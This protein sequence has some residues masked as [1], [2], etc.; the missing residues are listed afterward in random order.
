LKEDYEAIENYKIT[1]NIEEN[2]PFAAGML[3]S[4]KMRICDWSDYQKNIANLKNKIESHHKVSQPMPILGLIDSPKLQKQIAIQWCEKKYPKK[5]NS[6]N[7]KNNNEKIVLGYFSSDF[8]NHPV[9]L[10]MAEMFQLHDKNK[11]K[12][13]AFYYG[14]KTN[15]EVYL[16]VGNSFDKFI[17]V[18][19]LHDEEVAN[20]SREL[21]ID[22]AID[23]NGHT[24]RSKTGVFSYRAA[25]IQLSYIGYL[26]TMGADYYDYLV[27][28][29]S[30]IPV[31]LQHHY[32][33]KIVY[34][35]SYQ[36]NDSK[37]KI[38]ISNISRQELN[39][40]SDGF[41]YC[42]FN[43]SYKIT[44]STFDGWMR[45]L[46]LVPNSILLLYASNQSVEKNLKNEAEKRAVNPSRLIFG[47][48]LEREAYLARYR[49]ADL[50]LDT[51][52]YN[53]GAT[54]SDAL[55]AGLPVL[56]C[57]GESFASRV[58]G[59]LL[60]AIG[61]PELITKT[62]SDYEAL[63]IELGNNPSKLNVIK[64]KLENNRWTT[65]LFD[66][67]RFTKK[68]EEAYIKIY[69]RYHADLPPDH[70]YIDP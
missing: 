49:S 33:E 18:S 38:P 42:C 53:A 69:D 21:R 39:L 4:C 34:L 32:S 6:L 17:N 70:I 10:L 50:F 58:A 67:P 16:R 57:M 56:T 60:N 22:I 28:D 13:V 24:A 40:P 43:A 37:Q 52:P 51:M 31:E 46:S 3:L 23:L 9:S 20:L 66:T 64:E 36:V 41:V 15:D 44:P 2:Y 1:L 55:W 63:A 48:K 30:I 12:T 45:I 5:N 27:A 47:K 59:S 19:E 11:F 8:R 25:P 65:P 54:A 61:L 29:R 7:I 62:Q 26:G 14:P 35:P 68:I